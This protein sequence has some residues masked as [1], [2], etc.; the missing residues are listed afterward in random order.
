MKRYLL[1]LFVLLS[2]IVINAQTKELLNI[3]L[4]ARADFQQDYI[5]NDKVSANSGFKG[6]YLMLRMDGNIT[7]NFS[8]SYRQ[9]LNKTHLD[10]TF[11]DATDWLHLS[12]KYKSWS[13]SAG[14]QIV[15]I[16]GYEYDRVPIDLYF[17]SE[18]WANI[19]CYQFGASL[20]YT[21]EAGNDKFL[22]QF[23]ESP[24]RRN[25]ANVANKEM[26]AYNLM[27]YGSHNWFNSIYSLNM[28]EYLPGRFISYITLGNKFNFGDFS[29]EF[30]AMS[31][32]TDRHVFF[33]KN[34]SLIG[35]LS[36]RPKECVNIFAKA[37]YDVN[38]SGDNSDYCVA[39]GTELT[40]VGA[41]VEYYPIKD[42]RLHAQGCYI[43]GVNGNSSF[44]EQTFFSLGVTW[45]MNF[46]L[47]I[48]N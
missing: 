44:N 38:K 1:T 25:A 46:R 19:A 39:N 22:F 18:Y 6:K 23:C 47:N 9:R 20:S 34:L 29:L 7:K 8:Y 26:Y 4:D 30:D 33:G 16:G 27:W 45:R 40:R 10:Q 43:W 13:V 42:V 48:S 37:T 5:G 21:T 28:L 32:A 31:R 15:A 17:C 2:F 41:G 35:E 36:W 3:R 11:F 24:F 14:K 12:Y